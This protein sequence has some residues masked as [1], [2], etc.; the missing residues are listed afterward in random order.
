MAVSFDVDPSLALI[1]GLERINMTCTNWGDVGASADAQSVDTG[2]QLYSLAGLVI[3]PD[4]DVDQVDFSSVTGFGF[5]K[6]GSGQEITVGAPFVGDAAG[7]WHG[8]ATDDQKYGDGFTQLGDGA[9]H[10]FGPTMGVAG[11]MNIWGGNLPPAGQPQQYPALRLIAYLRPPSIVPVTR[12]PLVDYGGDYRAW[13]LVDP[14]VAAYCVAGRRRLHVVFNCFSTV[15]VSSADV[16]LTGLLGG[17][18]KAKE[19][20]ITAPQTLNA[21]VGPPEVQDTVEIKIDNLDTYW[22]MIRISNPVGFAD[23]NYKLRA[24]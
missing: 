9:G 7:I 23:V 15:G 21:S 17:T 18:N 2:N 20:A 1:R 11:G 6:L 3:A 13:Q 5:P 12:L 10:V 16:Q 24:E 19:F 4:S 14:I 8:V 22:L